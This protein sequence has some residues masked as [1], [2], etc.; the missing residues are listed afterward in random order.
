VDL[1]LDA[2]GEPPTAAAQASTAAGAAAAAGPAPK[3]ARPLSSG[4]AAPGARP[5]GAGADADQG[6][7]ALEKDIETV[8][9][10]CKADIEVVAKVWT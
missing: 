2:D 4:K 9:D 6:A 3:G 7:V 5:G 1:G 8:I 10:A